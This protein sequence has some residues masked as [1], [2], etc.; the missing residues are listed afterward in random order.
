MMRI[1]AIAFCF[2]AGLC[3]AG[4]EGT[5]FPWINF[6]GVALFALVPL[7]ARKERV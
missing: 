2:V 7:L 3:L 6:A 1:A 5:W 4:S